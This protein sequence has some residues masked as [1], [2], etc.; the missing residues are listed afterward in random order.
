MSNTR[1]FSWFPLSQSVYGMLTTVYDQSALIITGVPKL[2]LSLFALKLPVPLLGIFRGWLE[3]PPDWYRAKQNRRFF[4]ITNENTNTIIWQPLY[5]V[6][7]FS[8]SFIDLMLSCIQSSPEKW[9]RN[10]TR[11]QLHEGSW[12]SCHANSSSV[13]QGKIRTTLICTEIPVDIWRSWTTR[14]YSGH[15]ILPLTGATFFG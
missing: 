7:C 13:F 15:Q 11:K 9:Q 8:W 1:W 3:D 10:E 2:R 5:I 4:P 12:Q 14:P 6:W